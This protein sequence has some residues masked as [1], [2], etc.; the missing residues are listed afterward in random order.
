MAEN[1]KYYWLKLKRDFFK[2]HDIQ[3]IEGMPNGKDYILFYLKLLCESVDHDGSLRFSEEIPYNDQMLATITNTNVDIVRSA[4]KLFVELRM[5]EIMDDGTFYMTQV[6]KM[7]GGETKWAEKK[8]LQRAKGD[9]VPELSPICPTEIEKDKEEDKDKEKEIHSFIHSCASEEEAYINR[10]VEEEG[11]E[12]EDAEVY[13]EEIKE[14]LRLKY[15]GG[16]LGQGVVLM[17]DEQ[18]GDLCDKLSLDELEK[19][20]GIIVDCERNGKRYKKKSHY[21]AILEMAQKDRR[22]SK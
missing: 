2:R 1:G 8:R 14:N 6:E 20:M 9:N 5:M 16:T 3:I 18:F 17:S 11:F 22:I 7:I 10:R 13:R 19:Y 21:Q 12:G 15:I 4:V